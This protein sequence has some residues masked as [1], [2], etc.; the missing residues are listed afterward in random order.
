MEYGGTG[1]SLAMSWFTRLSV[2][3]E[4]RRAYFLWRVLVLG[5]YENYSVVVGGG[6]STLST[7]GTGDGGDRDS[8]SHGIIW[9]KCCG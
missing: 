9:G 4:R 8:L 3:Y 5:C 7:I 2:S 6:G 1:G